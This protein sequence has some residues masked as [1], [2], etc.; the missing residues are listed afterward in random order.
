MSRWSSISGVS[1][2]IGHAYLGITQFG[3]YPPEIEASLQSLMSFVEY[4]INAI[5]DV[6]RVASEGPVCLAHAPDPEED[7]F[8]SIIA[9]LVGCPRVVAPSTGQMKAAGASGRASGFSG[10]VKNSLKLA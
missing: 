5:D 9:S 3:P 7:S 4:R 1:S 6:A 8:E 10:R 2:D